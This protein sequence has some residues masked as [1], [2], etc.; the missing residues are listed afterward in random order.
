MDDRPAEAGNGALDVSD[1][2]LEFLA[3]SKN[4]HLHRAVQRL[5]AE[6]AK[7]DNVIARF[8]SSI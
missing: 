3:H 4:P 1:A 6:A 5:L 8:G 7:P 2:D